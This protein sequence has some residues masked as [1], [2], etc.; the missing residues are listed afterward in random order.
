MIYPR[1]LNRVWQAGLLLKLKCY[2][3]SGHMFGLILFYLSN[4][5]IWVVLDGKSSKKYQVNAGV[6]E[7]SILAHKLFYYTLMVCNIAIYADDNDND[8]WQQLELASEVESDP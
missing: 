2:E 5:Q 1:L 4:S 6:P 8:Q 3:I 7:G